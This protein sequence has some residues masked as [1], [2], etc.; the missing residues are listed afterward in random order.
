MDPRFDSSRERSPYL[1]PRIRPQTRR[2]QRRPRARLW[3]ALLAAPYLGF[4]LAVAA[5]RALYELGYPVTDEIRETVI[6]ASS[7]WAAASVR[8]AFTFPAAGL[9]ERVVRRMRGDSED[10]RPLALPIVVVA[11]YFVGIAEMLVWCGYVSSEHAAVKV[12]EI[13]LGLLSLTALPLLVV[14]AVMVLKKRGVNLR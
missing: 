7:G 11:L 6:R 8:A 10:S 13:S 12:V 2:A 14:L 5:F 3:W 1:P 9:L 4:L